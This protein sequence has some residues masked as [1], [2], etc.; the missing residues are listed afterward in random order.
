MRTLLTLL[1]MAS[2]TLGQQ[3]T[4]PQQGPPPKN[5]TKGADG[6]ITA[7]HDPANP[8]KF[9]VYTVKAGDTLSQIAGVQ[10]KNPRLWPQLW[11]QNEHIVNPHWIY[12]NDKILIKPIQLI[13]EAPPPPAP[14]PTPPPV[15]E[16]P[17]PAPAPMVAPLLPAPV[18]PKPMGPM[19]D[20][21]K[22]NPIPEIKQNDLYCSGFIRKAAVPALNKITAKY[23]SDNGALAV[24]SNYIYISQG[25][26]DGVKPGDRFQV[27]RPTKNIDDVKGETKTDRDLGRHYLDVGQ[28]QVVS[29]QPDFSLARVT[30]SCEAMEIGD[31]MLPFQKVDVPPIPKARPFSPFMKTSGGLEGYIVMTRGVL[32]NFGSI[33]QASGKIAGSRSSDLADVEK[34][35]AGTGAI[36]YVDLGRDTGVKPG[37][38]FIVYRPVGVDTRLYPSMPKESKVVATTET[39][40]GEIV[41]LKVEERASTALVTY[42]LTGLSAQDSVSRR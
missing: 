33:F 5:L 39:A 7:N 28:I 11:E 24:Q 25:S 31:I 23:N 9:E 22:P 38:V 42:A 13:T 2:V 10:M 26:E 19:I 20:I 12:P 1:L 15:A 8:E 35:I 16:A 36:V 3:K 4:V 27:V 29:T 18:E 17:R 34:G 37:D 14:E 41:I 30:N 40:I 32:E 21:R 6:H